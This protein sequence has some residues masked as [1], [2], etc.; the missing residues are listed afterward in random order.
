MNVDSIRSESKN[1]NETMLYGNWK[2]EKK[3]KLISLNGNEVS[4]KDSEKKGCGSGGKGKGSASVN[5]GSPSR[6]KRYS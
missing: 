5:E 2:R 4:I 1:P 3:S 6:G